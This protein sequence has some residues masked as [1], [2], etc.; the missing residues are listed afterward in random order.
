MRELLCVGFLLR[1]LT[2]R[3]ILQELGVHLRG[4]ELHVFDHRATNEAVL[5]RLL[6][7]GGA[8]GA[9]SVQRR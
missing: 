9:I 7:G 6:Q 4:G 2:A 3:R 1:H 5:D 8:S